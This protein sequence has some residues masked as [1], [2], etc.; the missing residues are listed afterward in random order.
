[1]AK[2]VVCGATKTTKTMIKVADRKY[3]CDEECKQKY[4]SDGETKTP[5]QELLDCVGTLWENPSYPLIATQ[6]KQLQ[7]TYNF[8]VEGMLL[9]LKYCFEVEDKS[10][11]LMYGFK[12]LLERYYN[13]AKE[14]YM[15]SVKRKKALDEIKDDEIVICKANDGR[16]KLSQFRTNVRG[17]LD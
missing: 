5:R 1:M 12:Y 15:D 7:D 10:S 16:R 3:V 8:K 13:E 6:I 11:E 14:F 4:E 9:T 2:C 17:V